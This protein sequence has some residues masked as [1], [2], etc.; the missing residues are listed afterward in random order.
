MPMPAD[1]A[2]APPDLDYRLPRTAE[3]TAY[4]LTLA[5][6]LET[7]TF[8]GEVSIELVV[9]RSTDRL[10]CNAA[11][12]TVADAVLEPYGGPPVPATVTLDE[13]AERATFVFDTSVPA[14]R[15]TLRCS[16]T[17]VLN[18][19]LRGFYRSTFTTDG[20]ATRTIATTQM[21]ST[22]ARRA[23]PCWDE[24]DRKAVFEV[25]L[26]I[27][28]ELAAF[29]NSAVVN[30]HVLPPDDRWAGR[31]AV[32]FAPTMKMSTYLV[33]FVVGPLEVTE[34]IDVDGVPVRVV[35]APGKA[36]LTGY[37]LEV[38]AHAL[39]FFSDYFAIPYPADKLDLV[40]IPD[41]AFGAMENLGCVT[42]RETALLV[43]PDEGRP[44][45]ARTDRRRG[46]PR[47]RPHVVRRP[48]H[49]AVVGG[50]LAQRG[51]RHLHGGPLRRRTFGPPGRRWVSFGLE[52][53]AA[54]AID[55]L[56]TT[57]PIE[58]PVGSARGGGRDVRRA[59]LPEGWQRA[60]HAGAV[61]RPGG[62]PRR[63]ASLSD[64]P[65]LRQHRHRRTC[66]TPSRT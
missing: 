60:A 48:G 62:V 26:V 49:D 50:D 12:L 17:G 63:G 65:R 52:R 35:H 44:H 30:E 20:G 29:S 34:P 39:R 8:A 27:D 22:D 47:D 25:T 6:D 15:A 42:F 9:H 45:R 36:G 14:G 19:K 61:P 32:R 2:P 31:R 64:R 46:V 23:F 55:G 54:L 28:P 5:P 11:E 3:P 33:A 58:Y 40:A 10:V 66:G 53:E 43:D 59:H 7:A 56:H 41:F 37:A 13:A 16:F 51:L 1:P 38:A 21:E 18:D 24:P 57:R 4:R